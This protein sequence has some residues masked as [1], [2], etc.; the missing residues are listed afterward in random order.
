[1][2]P[3]H[4]NQAVQSLASLNHAANASVGLHQRKI[5]WVAA[6]LG[7][8]STTYGVFVLVAAWVA[9]NLALAA[10]GGRPLD[11]P[12]FFWLQGTLTLSSLLMMTIVLTTQAR[13]TRHAEDRSRIDMQI[14]LLSEAKMA[15]LIAL[16]EELRRD[17]P[18]V[19]NRVDPVADEMQEMVDPARV[20]DAI[21]KTIGLAESDD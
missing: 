12:P 21:E 8:P 1:M 15:K 13:Q 10:R 9:L 5:E 6:K 19:P 18:L 17:L 16:V 4:V 14:S 7:R 2:V 3:E 11:P 20:L